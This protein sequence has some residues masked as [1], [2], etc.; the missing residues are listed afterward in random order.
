MMSESANSRR[1]C[2][3]GFAERKRIAKK[4]VNFSPSFLRSEDF[5]LQ[6][7]A[8]LRNHAGIEK[9]LITS[10]NNAALRSENARKNSS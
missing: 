4:R 5:C 9:C 1:S 10:D 7:R 8:I 6:N 3:N 2:R